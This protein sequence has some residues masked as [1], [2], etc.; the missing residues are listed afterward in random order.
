MTITNLIPTVKYFWFEIYSSIKTK[1]KIRCKKIYEKLKFF[2]KVINCSTLITYIYMHNNYYTYDF[3]KYYEFLFLENYFKLKTKNFLFVKYFKK[4]ETYNYVNYFHFLIEI[5][6]K[7]LKYNKNSSNK[8]SIIIKNIVSNN[9]LFNENLHLKIQDKKQ[10]TMSLKKLMKFKLKN[11]NVKLNQDNHILNEKI[12]VKTQMKK[13]SIIIKIIFLLFQVIYKFSTSFLLIGLNI[14]KY[15]ISNYFLNYLNLL[16]TNFYNGI[17][18]NELELLKKTIDKNKKM[19]KNNLLIKFPENLTHKYNF[20]G[21]NLNYFSIFCCLSRFKD[22]NFSNYLQTVEKMSNWNKFFV[23]YEYIFNEKPLYGL[24][25]D[26]KLFFENKNISDYIKSGT[27]LGNI[28]TSKV[29]NECIYLYIKNFLN[30]LENNNKNSVFCY[31]IKLSLAL[32]ISNIGLI[33]KSLYYWKLLKKTIINDDLTAISSYF[34]LGMIYFGTSSREIL[35][36][37]IPYLYETNSDKIKFSLLLCLSLVFFGS[38]NESLNIYKILMKE[39]DLT[40]KKGA[41]LILSLGYFGTSNQFVIKILLNTFVSENNSVL[42]LY[43]LQGMGWVSFNSPETTLKIL[44]FYAKSYNPFIRLGSAFGIF[45]SSGINQKKKIIKIFDS[46]QYDK[47]DFVSQIS[48]IF[49]SF[50]IKKINTFEKEPLFS[51]FDSNNDELFESYLKPEIFIQKGIFL[52]N[53]RLRE[54]IN[55]GNKINNK[56]LYLIM[57]LSYI[58]W[59]PN[60]IFITQL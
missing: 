52:S 58:D 23:S 28:H 44:N 50:Y 31:G 19:I 8:N 57:F 5:R 1:L 14:F 22:L 51:K 6:I 7:N 39:K 25:N 33:F 21:I 10:F 27:V 36:T 2:I 30:L 17:L 59:V 56:I 45:L 4:N 42:K 38:N 9:D 24:T 54:I 13:Y 53:I 47:V 15:F 12:I 48:K 40:F 20:Q 41:I 49:Y 60:L 18:L 43:I 16:Y 29:D 37:L 3:L 46:L 32:I 34:C 35:K 55:Y 26:L 11:K